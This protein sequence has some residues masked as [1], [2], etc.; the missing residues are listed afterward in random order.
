L[1]KIQDDYAPEPIKD[2]LI[3]GFSYLIS[4]DVLAVWF[5]SIYTK[6]GYPVEDISVDEDDWKPSMTTIPFGPYLA[7]GALVCMLFRPELSSL[8]DGYLKSITG[9]GYVGN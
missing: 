1:K 2:L 6:M 3:L 5:P 8:A 4:L 9:T 7:I